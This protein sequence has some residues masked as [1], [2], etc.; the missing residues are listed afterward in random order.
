[1]N[2][3][4][5]RPGELSGVVVEVVVVVV[6]V[7]VVVDAVVNDEGEDAAVRSAKEPSSCGW[8]KRMSRHDHGQNRLTAGSTFFLFIQIRGQGLHGWSAEHGGRRGRGRARLALSRIGSGV[9]F[10]L[11]Q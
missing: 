11:L 4:L 3:R 1:M 2:L 8:A 6:V 7:K 9:H 10:A 5:H